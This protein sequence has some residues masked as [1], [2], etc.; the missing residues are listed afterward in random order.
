VPRA[1]LIGKESISSCTLPAL[2]LIVGIVALPSLLV[3]GIRI[4]SNGVIFDVDDTGL[5]ESEYTLMDLPS[6]AIN[7]K[8]EMN[9]SAMALDSWN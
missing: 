7:F 5:I 4:P 9:R 1:K 3:L 8:A 2:C 6:P